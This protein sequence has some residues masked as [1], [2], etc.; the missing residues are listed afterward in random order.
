MNQ[1]IHQWFDGKNLIWENFVQCCPQKLVFKPP[2]NFAQC[3]NITFSRSKYIP[4][5]W[6]RSFKTNEISAT[7]LEMLI[8]QRF[9]NKYIFF[10]KSLMMDKRLMKKR[11][12]ILS[13]AIDAMELLHKSA[14]KCNLQLPSKPFKCRFEANFPLT[15]EQVCERDSV[16]DFSKAWCRSN[17]YFS[18]NQLCYTFPTVSLFDGHATKSNNVFFFL[19]KD[20]SATRRYLSCLI[21]TLIG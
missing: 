18:F 9:V 10:N 17:I 14:L 20:H 11:K 6:Y 4:V 2:S 3:Y 5:V 1:W 8:P 13:C 12:L 21:E 15:Y 19:Y 16:S 7:S